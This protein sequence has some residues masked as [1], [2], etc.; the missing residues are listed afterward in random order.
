MSRPKTA[1]GFHGI[2]TCLA[3]IAVA[4][5]PA[6]A[7][8]NS[9]GSNGVNS[10]GLTLFG[11]AV[12]DGSGIAIGMAEN[13]R[14]G[15]ANLDVDGEWYWESNGTAGYQDGEYWVELK[16]NGDLET[17][18]YDANYKNY[19]KDVVPAAVY[20]RAGAVP[21]RTPQLQGPTPTDDLKFKFES[22]Y[23]RDFWSPNDHQVSDHSTRVAGVMIARR[24]GNANFADRGVAPA[25]SLYADAIGIVGTPD[26]VIL[27]LQHV[28]RQSDIRAMN[29]SYGF[30]IDTP[31]GLS[32]RSLA[33]DYL[34]SL[35]DTLHVVAGD[36]SLPDEP[37]EKPLAPSDAFNI[38]N[39]GS[40]TDAGREGTG[41]YDR[42]DSINKYFDLGGPRI[43]VHLVAPGRQVVMPRLGSNGYRAE[44][45]T[46]FAAPHVAGAAALLQEYGKDRN[47]AGAARFDASYR[48]HQVMK[49]VLLNSADKVKDTG[50]G[51]LL[52][53]E[54]TI[55]R[56]DATAPDGMR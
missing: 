30:Q 27:S 55:Y 46:S 6:K 10:R 29:H 56:Y 44:T 41:L 4:C 52:G 48:Q 13:G 45:G 5:P 15:I 42:Y 1:P 17:L 11:G 35:Y 26:N 43:R 8:E 12:L 20:F 32:P 21:S 53:M 28:Q 49:V 38:I 2:I 39:V 23:D 25:A 22:E 40:L 18:K 47:D 54:K 19:H 37:S 3:L 14:P 31:D 34:S 24:D 51:M 9:A 36:Q 50:D 7:G 16:I 33:V